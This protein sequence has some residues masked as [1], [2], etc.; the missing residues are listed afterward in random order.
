MVL[1]III[2]LCLLIVLIYLLW[3]L[4]KCVAKDKNIDR[5]FLVVSIGAINIAFLFGVVLCKL[6]ISI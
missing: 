1:C 2:A 3:E 4:S 5:W 6:I